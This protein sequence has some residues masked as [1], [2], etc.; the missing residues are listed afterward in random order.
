MSLIYIAARYSRRREA[1]K[2]AK[3]LE[4][5]GHT[6]TA[7]WLEGDHRLPR[8]ADENRAS[9]WSKLATDD[10]ED[11][12]GCDVLIFLSEP[13]DGS[14]TRGGRHVEVGLAL[15]WGRRVI[16]VGRRENIFHWLPQVEVV[17]E[18]EEVL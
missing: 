4:S 3:Q 7:R 9:R 10:F 5:R 2:L 18:I 16:I 12:E 17:S 1:V 13:K 15:A 6:V 14:S 11:V 8:E